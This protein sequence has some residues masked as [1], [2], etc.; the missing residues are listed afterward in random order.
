M[1]FFLAVVLVIAILAFVGFMIVLCRMKG[2]VT[3]RF[4][5]PF[6]MTFGFEAKE[7]QEHSQKGQKLI[8]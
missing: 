8:K 1:Q 6:V 5:I 2:D 3:A 4:K 7:R